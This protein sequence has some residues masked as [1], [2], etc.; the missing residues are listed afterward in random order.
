MFPPPFTPAPEPIG[1]VEEIHD[2]STP[3]R[4]DLSVSTVIASLPS[5]EVNFA[6][7]PDSDSGSSQS[8]PVSFSIPLDIPLGPVSVNHLH[9][10]A[11][12][13]GKED[14]PLPF[15]CLLDSGA[16][17]VLIRPETVKALDLPILKLHEPEL[18]SLALKQNSGATPFTDYVSLSLSTLNNAWTS[19]PVPAII[20]PNLC[21]DILLGLPF[22]SHNKIVI[23]HDLRTA[24]HK[25]TNIDLLND[26]S[27][28]P[29]NPPP[30]IFPKIKRNLL[31]KHC[32]LFMTELKMA[33]AKRLRFLEINNA[34]EKPLP[35]NPI[36][37][38]K[39]AITIL[40]S[41]DKLNNL[42]TSLKNEFKPLF[43]PIP[44][45]NELPT[46]VTA[47]IHLKNAYET[48]KNRTYS[49]PR[50]YK[51][52]FAKL[53]QMRLDSG[54]IRPSSSPFASPSFIIPKKN[55]SAL[56][57]WV[58]DYRQLN[59]NT[60]PDSFPLPLIDD[61]LA[62]CA[63]GKI[64][65]TIDMTD[66]FFQTRMHPDDIHK[67]AVSTPFGLYEWLVMPM[68]FR[69]APAIHQ[70]RVTN[71]LR[72]LIGKICH[73]YLDDIVIWSDSVDEHIKNTCTVM[74]ALLDAKL[75][76]NEK[77]THLFCT[78][79]T[80]LGHRI[81]QFGIEADDT[82]ASRILDWPIP[83]SATE[84]RQFLGLIMLPG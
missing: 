53:I 5:S 25:P 81:S 50:Q 83:T 65:G 37:A 78:S 28:A 35:F 84:V 63:R 30:K 64:W 2:Q 39:D 43:Q 24:T 40:A 61:I 76:V 13:H 60:I 79:I 31:I 15:N 56:P 74:Q 47:R 44:H 71:A 27:S 46:T 11:A 41:K 29:R 9:W 12:A 67:T 42:E 62:D 52:A 58:C 16:H 48:I 38:I 4:T 6:L 68:G 1:F 33:C 26:N 17:L 69:N 55:P 49:C 34:F 20:A 72:H 80:F 18:V 3:N 75:Y 22:L 59:A 77:R 51:D 82:K 8:T 23:D 45:V 54:F 19:L 7:S 70:Q 36:C 32:R 14:F 21:T 57:R 10:K 73:V 66:S